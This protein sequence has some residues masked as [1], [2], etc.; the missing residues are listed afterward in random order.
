MVDAFVTQ[1][2]ALRAREGRLYTDDVLRCLPYPQGTAY[3]SEWSVRARSARRLRRYFAQRT[4]MRIL[5]VGCGNGWL[6]HYLSLIP[7]CE[8]LGIDVN[9]FELEQAGRVFHRPNLS[10]RQTDLA[11]LHASGFD[12]ILFAASFQY[13]ADVKATLGECFR[14]LVRG[15]SVL[16]I[17]TYFYS[18]KDRAAARTR[19]AAYFEAL[20]AAALKAWYFHHSMEDF[21]PFRY[22]VR[23]PLS[24]GL[25]K[26]A[27]PV[28]PWLQIDRP[29]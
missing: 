25:R 28:F 5:E 11:A 1:Y 29:L 19:S 24:D 2:L 20:G 13:F 9:G 18:S 22:R 4:P 17:D 6:S 23:N 12:C 3:T 16:I 14:R 10:F 7:S 27:G 8:V 26:L 21:A 15:G